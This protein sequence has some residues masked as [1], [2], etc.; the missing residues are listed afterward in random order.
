MGRGPETDKKTGTKK[1]TETT[2][3]GYIGQGYLENT[4]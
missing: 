3:F 1:R 4:S 2:T